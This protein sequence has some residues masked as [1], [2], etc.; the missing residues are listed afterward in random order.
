MGAFPRLIP[1]TRPLTDEETE[2]QSEGCELDVPAQGRALHPLPQCLQLSAFCVP[3]EKLCARRTHV[4]VA[5]GVLCRCVLSLWD[6]K[7]LE[8]RGSCPS[9]G[10]IT[11]GSLT[12]TVC[13]VSVGLSPG[14]LP[15][16]PT[17]GQCP[18]SARL[19]GEN[20]GV[21]SSPWGLG[22]RGGWSPDPVPRA[23][24]AWRL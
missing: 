24:L 6:D 3:S 7:H 20:T 9:L 15:W 2:A 17:A 12:P 13:S 1:T 16:G 19:P 23:P 5:G 14:S 22:V 21:F 8:G 4:N 18:L 10:L 11:S